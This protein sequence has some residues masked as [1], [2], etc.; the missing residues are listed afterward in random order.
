MFFPKYQRFIEDQRLL[1]NMDLVEKSSVTA[2]LE[3]YYEKHPLDNS[4]EGILARKTGLTKE[5][6]IATIDT[7]NY[8]TFIAN[9]NPDGYYPL[10][11]Q[12]PEEEKLQIENNNY[13]DSESYISN[14]PF[15][16]LDTKRRYDITAYK[17]T[18]T[19]LRPPIFFLGSTGKFANYHVP[20]SEKHRR[21]TTP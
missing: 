13:I 2:F 8:L 5:N 20:H 14:K 9:Y 21:Y 16:L 15:Y 10:N 17:N 3:D 4:F 18:E 1:E 12:A 6:V 19:S 11:Y 7:I